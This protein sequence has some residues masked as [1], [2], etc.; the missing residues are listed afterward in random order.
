MT[1]GFYVT[2]SEASA[3][4]YKPGNGRGRGWGAQ[5]SSASL[6]GCQQLGV[7]PTCQILTNTKVLGSLCWPS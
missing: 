5:N 2:L 4:G 6:I 3:W 7:G 1:D